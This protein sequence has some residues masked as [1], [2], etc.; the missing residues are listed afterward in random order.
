VCGTGVPPVD[1]RK[2]HPTTHDYIPSLEIFKEMIIAGGDVNNVDENGQTPL[3]MAVDSAPTEVIEILLKK[4]AHV[5]AK[6]KY[7]RT[8]LHIVCSGS[9]SFSS[10]K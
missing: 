6:D 2:R 8:A 9:A 5:N 4:G 10:S 3:M 7:G 1:I